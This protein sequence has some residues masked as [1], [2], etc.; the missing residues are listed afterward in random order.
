M[1]S[2]RTQKNPQKY[3]FISFG[4]F[5]KFGNKETSR[6]RPLVGTR[7]QGTSGMPGAPRWVVPTWDT[8]RTP[9]FYNLLVPQDKKSIYTSRTC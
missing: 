8:F 4:I 1:V 2:K 5:K 7:H 3:F 9:F 6:K